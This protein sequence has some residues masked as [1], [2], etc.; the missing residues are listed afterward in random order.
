MVSSSSKRRH[1]D[2]V[3]NMS[4]DRFSSSVGNE[5]TDGKIA[6]LMEHAQKKV[7]DNLVRDFGASISHTLIQNTKDDVALSRRIKQCVGDSRKL[8]N[9]VAD[10][11]KEPHREPSHAT[12]LAGGSRSVGL[13]MA[14]R[15]HRLARADS[16]AAGERVERL[17]EVQTARDVPLPL[18]LSKRATMESDMTKPKLHRRNG[19]VIGVDEK[20]SFMNHAPSSSSADMHNLI[21]KV[22]DAMQTEL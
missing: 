17:L 1:L 19:L 10:F 16:S 18:S 6:R 22:S 8:L 2:L 11:L 13:L 21:Q 7:E 4:R 14:E 5:E 20:E 12:V 9:E 15:T 3:R